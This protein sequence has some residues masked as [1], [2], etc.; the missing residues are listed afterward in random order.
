M[1]VH[2][3]QAGRGH[4]IEQILGT[5]GGV[6]KAE[7]EVRGTL[8]RRGGGMAHN[9]KFGGGIA[10]ASRDGPLRRRQNGT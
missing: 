8:F 6:T 7:K 10:E 9:M 4:G 1:L 2:F 5:R 3:M